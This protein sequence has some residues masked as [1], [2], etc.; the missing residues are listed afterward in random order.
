[1]VA[2]TRPEDGIQPHRS[3]W[4]SRRTV[5]RLGTRS[6]REVLQLSDDSQVSVARGRVEDVRD[7]IETYLDDIA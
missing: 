4:V 6:G 1:M 3:W 2:Q 7:W 5:G